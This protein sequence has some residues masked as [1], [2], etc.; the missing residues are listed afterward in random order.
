MMFLTNIGSYGQF[1]RAESNFSLGARMMVETSEYLLPHAPHE[2]PL[3]KTPLQYWLIGMAYKI[4]GFNYGASRIPSALCGL[5]VLTFVYMLGFRFHGKLAGLTAS[6]MLGTT[7]L[8]WSFARL[9]MPDML[10]TLCITTTL[11]CWGLVLMEQTKHSRALVVM[12]YAAIGL[13]F[14][15][16]GPVAI[17]L[18]FLPICLEILLSRD[19]T[20]IRKLQPISGL[21]TFLLVTTPYFLLVYIYDGVEPLRN[22]FIEEN[23]RRFTGSAY[24]TSKPRFVYELTAFL[25]DFLPWSPL[26]ITTGWWLRRWK[27]ISQTTRRQLRWLGVWIASPILF[28][29]VSSFKLDY[30]FLLSVPPAALLVTLTLLQEGPPSIWARRFGRTIA[31]LLVLLLPVLLYV[32]IQ[33]VKVN[34]PNTPFAWIPHIIALATII[35]AIWFI[36]RRPAY[37]A[38]FAFAFTLW[39]TTFSTYFFL[40]PDYTRFQPTEALA[41][42]VPPKARVFAVGPANE[43]T[44]DLALFLPTSQLVIPL[45]GKVTEKLPPILER[46]PQTVFLIYEQEYGELQKAG[47]QLRVIAQAEAY[48]RNRLTLRSLLEPNHE[49]LFLVAQ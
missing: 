40:L 18:S 25:A 31:V 47:I 10:L 19:W 14:L 46:Y 8:F 6:A 27:T 35:P 24:K 30:Y 9:S 22:F 3:N 7:Y 29:S 48:R 15:A 43:W 21:L 37:Q 4:F 36:I 5:G 28:F 45:P 33:M 41:A 17:V 1:L 20:I 44:W 38:V 32:T 23:L 49:Q 16:K 39:A 26:L 13:G 12:G 42:E 11:V 2:L 34:F